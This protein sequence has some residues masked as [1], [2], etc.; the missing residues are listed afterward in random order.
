MEIMSKY[1]NI[2][3][4]PNVLTYHLVIKSMAECFITTMKLAQPIAKG[5]VE[6]EILPIFLSQQ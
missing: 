1:R 5:V 4:T 3:Y 6:T 2:K